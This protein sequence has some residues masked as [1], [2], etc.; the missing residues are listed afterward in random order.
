MRT[1]TKKTKVDLVAIKKVLEQE[2]KDITVP[3][4]ELFDDCFNFVSLNVKIGK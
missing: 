2:K 4:Q 1:R 3:L